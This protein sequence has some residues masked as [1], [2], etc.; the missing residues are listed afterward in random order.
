MAQAFGPPGCSEATERSTLAALCFVGK[1]QEAYILDTANPIERVR[2][3]LRRVYPGQMLAYEQGLAHAARAAAS[4]NRQVAPAELAAGFAETDAK[5][6]KL[7]AEHDARN[8][9]ALRAAAQEEARRAEAQ[10]EL[11]AAFGIAPKGGVSFDGL[12]QTFSFGG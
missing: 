12:I 1:K 2:S 5:L 7:E 11:D 6:R 4:T 9:S 8:A 3:E 10:R